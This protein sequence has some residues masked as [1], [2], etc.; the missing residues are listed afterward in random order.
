MSEK[1]APVDGLS[2]YVEHT[3]P[4]PGLQSLSSADHPACSHTQCEH[5]SRQGNSS[6]VQMRSKRQLPFHPV[7]A[8]GLQLRGVHLPPGLWGGDQSGF[9]EL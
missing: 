6:N 8:P 1:L 9:E 7:S 5:Q 4:T 2:S 3:C